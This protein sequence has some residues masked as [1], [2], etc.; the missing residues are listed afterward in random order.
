MVVKR[1]LHREESESWIPLRYC[2]RSLVFIIVSCYRYGRFLEA[3]DLLCKYIKPKD[4]ILVTGS[5]NSDLGAEMY[6]AGLKNITI[7]DDR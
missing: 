7:I 5:G 2:V 6:F 3:A 4:N 1:T